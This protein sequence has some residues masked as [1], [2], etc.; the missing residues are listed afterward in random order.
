MYV[1]LNL[2]QTGAMNQ[3]SVTK[4]GMREPKK[5]IR[6]MKDRVHAISDNKGGCHCGCKIIYVFK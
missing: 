3:L 4:E 6:K 5:F 1:D 2:L